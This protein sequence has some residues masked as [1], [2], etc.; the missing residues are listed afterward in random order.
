MMPSYVVGPLQPQQQQHLH[1]LHS[2]PPHLQNGSTQPPSNGLPC[3]QQH[4][5]Q[6]SMQHPQ[7]MPQQMLPSVTPTVGSNLPTQSIPNTSQHQNM[8]P[9]SQSQS[10]PQPPTHQHLSHM[11]PQYSQ[12]GNSAFVGNQSQQMMGGAN[13][14]AT[15]SQP[16]QLIPP[17]S[18]YNQ[19]ITSGNPN[20]IQMGIPN[21]Q[22]NPN[23]NQP[24]INNS[25]NMV[26]N[27]PITTSILPQSDSRN[28]IPIYQHQR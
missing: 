24:M 21:I 3:M 25:Q 22:Q 9:N 1:Q 12:V 26:M 16:S 2:M 17:N 11:N 27:Q 13:G 8:I 20:H 18:P 14:I 15:T 7:N 5:H 6:I 23:P 4:Q 10:M 28:S 19:H